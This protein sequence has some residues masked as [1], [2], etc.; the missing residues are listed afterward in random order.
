MFDGD[1]HL[2]LAAYNGGLGRLQRAMK[3]SG[4]TDFWSLASSSK[5]LPR[6]TRE[7]VPLILAAIVVAKNPVQDGF[8]I[9]PADPI[10][11]DKVAVPRAIDL[12]RVAEWTGSS[13]DE[14]QSLNPELRRWMTPVRYP[15]Y[16]VKVPTGTGD[17][18]SS[19]LA[20]ASPD[21]FVALNLYTV[22]RGETLSTIARKLRVSRAELA[23]ANHL[24]VKSRVQ[25][26]QSLII[27]R[28]PATL[29]A[30]RTQRVVPDEVASRAI[31]GS[32]PVAS[33]SPAARASTNAS[34]NGSNNNQVERS[35]DVPRQARRHAFVHRASLQHDG[36]QAEEPEPAS[37]HAHHARRSAHHPGSLT[38]QLPTPNSQLP[39]PNS[40]EKAGSWKLGVGSWALIGSLSAYL[41]SLGS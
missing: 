13:I 2:V 7:Y 15:E 29:L 28:A 40:Q 35:L 26:G 3:R 34:T 16:E 25:Q 27:P 20:S 22:K 10:D 8:N 39:I 32:A 33:A 24:S 38:Q 4:K 23:E 18:F 14:I 17:R 1:W 31:S 5:Y 19:R 30:T 11:Y 21:D 9:T 37:R 36:R 41:A 12:R 6:E